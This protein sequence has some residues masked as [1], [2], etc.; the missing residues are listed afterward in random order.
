M[1]ECWGHDSGW[2]IPGV[3]GHVMLLSLLMLQAMLEA[4]EKLAAA[5][6]RASVFDKK[7]KAELAARLAVRWQRW[8]LSNFDYLMQVVSTFAVR[9]HLAAVRARGAHSSVLY[10]Y[11][12]CLLVVSLPIIC[13]DVICSADYSRASCRGWQVR[14]QASA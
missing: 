11:R 7:R 2:S 13:S 12:A 4:T 3:L 1:T 9:Q 10:A 8:E 6:P 5:S 14:P